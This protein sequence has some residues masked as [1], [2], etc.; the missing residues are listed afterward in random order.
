MI[1]ACSVRQTCPADSTWVCS[2]DPGASQDWGAIFSSSLQ[3]LDLDRCTFQDIQG[4]PVYTQ[5]SRVRALLICHS[6]LLAWGH[7][8]M[9]PICSVLL[10]GV[11]FTFVP[12]TAHGACYRLAQV[13]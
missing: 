9:A 3:P 8:H 10:M 13:L 2:A 12:A 4:T 5:S 11:R 7:G 1:E 6:S